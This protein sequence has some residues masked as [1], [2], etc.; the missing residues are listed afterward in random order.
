MW[1]LND[2]TIK[3]PGS[4][5]NSTAE[6]IVKRKREF[7]EQWTEPWNRV[8]SRRRGRWRQVGTSQRRCF[9][10]PFTI[11]R[12]I[13]EPHSA[14]TCCPHPTYLLCTHQHP[15]LHSGIFSIKHLILGKTH[16]RE[17][18]LNTLQSHRHQDQFQHVLT[19]NSK[20]Q[21]RGIK[22]IINPSSISFT[23]EG[24]RGQVS[25]NTSYAASS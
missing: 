15:V 14:N 16:S 9:V 2:S 11:G 13:P 8:N 22:P 4:F 5:I 1:W 21:Q 19:P 17:H 18:R 24:V 23:P 12:G 7:V 25:N 6:E 3:Y 10:E 20:N